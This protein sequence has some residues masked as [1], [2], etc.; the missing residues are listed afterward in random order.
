MLQVLENKGI[1]PTPFEV[2]N[3]INKGY[4]KRCAEDNTSI[5][6][7]IVDK[8]LKAFSDVDA[9]WLITGIRHNESESERNVSDSDAYKMFLEYK[10]AK[11]EYEQAL[12]AIVKEKDGRIS[13]KDE[14]IK[15]KEYIISL[16]KSSQKSPESTLPP[17][18]PSPVHKAH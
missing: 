4:L 11:K 8:F 1:K 7:E 15:D 2:S 13:D 14:R 18:E 16:L 5:G 10:A 3:D 6:S 9:R 17:K 12:L